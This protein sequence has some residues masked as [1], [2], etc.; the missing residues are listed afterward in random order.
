MRSRA[1]KPDGAGRLEDRNL[2]SGTTAPH[3]P[4]LVSAYS[5]QQGQG[6]VQNAFELFAVSRDTP[7]N[8]ERLR[9]MLASD[10]RG[11]PFHAVSHLGPQTN[12]ILNQ[13]QADLAAGVPHAIQTAYQAVTAANQAQVNDSEQV[14]A[15]VVR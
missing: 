9:A 13:M 11:I 15:I 7:Q 8:F 5:L 6:M 2:M 1:F 4:V 3:G 14:G 12:A 10:A